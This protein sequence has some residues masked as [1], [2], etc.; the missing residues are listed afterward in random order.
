MKDENNVGSK[1]YADVTAYFDKAAEF[2]N[3]PKGLL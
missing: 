2:T 1:F 3:L